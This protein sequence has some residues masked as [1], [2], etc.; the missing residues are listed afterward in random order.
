MI[1]TQHGGAQ[2][3]LI[4][5]GAA[6]PSKRW[7][8]ARFGDVASFVRDVCKLVPIVLCGDRAKK[9]SPMKLGRRLDRP[10]CWHRPL[11]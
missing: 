11:A 6:W 10:R 3:A 2:D 9:R 7:P 8:A 5:A 1:R 4:N